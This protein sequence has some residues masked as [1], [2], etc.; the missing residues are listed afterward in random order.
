MEYGIGYAL[1]LG[2]DPAAPHAVSHDK[3]ITPVA[4]VL[5]S[6]L[7]QACLFDLQLFEQHAEQEMI[8]IRLADFAAIG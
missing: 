8:F 6:R 5:K 1:T 2:Y 3:E 7:Q 4:G